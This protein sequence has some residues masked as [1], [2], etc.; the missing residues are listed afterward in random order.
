MKRPSLPLSGVKVVDFGQYIAGPAVAMVLAD[1]G[2]IVVHIDPPSGPLWDS[3]ANATLNRNKLIVEIDLKTEEGLSQAQALVAEADIVVENFRPG[4]LSRL[5]IDFTA[6]RKVRPELITVSIP[7]FASND[8]LRREWRAFEAVIAASSGVFTDMGLDRVLMGVIP[9]FSPLPLASAYGTMLAASAAVLALQA[10]ERSGIGDHIE[11]PL[12]CAVMEALAYN[13]CLVENFPPRYTGHRSREIAQRREANLPLNL[14]YQ[15]VQDL[16]DPF[17][18]NSGYMCKD[19]RMFSIACAGHK[20]HIK[21]CLQALGLYD[22]LVSEGLVEQMDHYLALPLPKYWH[23]EITTRM[24]AVFLTRTSEE[25]ERIFRESRIAGSPQRSLKEWMSN[26]HA[27]AAGVVVEVDDPVFGRMTQPGP[28]AWLEETGEMMLN[29]APRKWVAFDEAIAA[30]SAIPVRR[31]P[32]RPAR[33]SSGWLDGVRVLD[34]S[35][36]IAGPHTAY[37]LARFGAEVIKIDPALPLYNC[38]WTV[39]MGMVNMCGKHS[40][41]VDIASPGG[42]KV[43][44]RLVKS[45]D[46]IVW[47]ATDQEVKRKGLHLEGLK[48]LNPDVIFCQVDCF[49]GV[50]GGPRSDDPGYDDIAQAA[51]GIML[52]FGGSPESPEEHAHY[53]TIDALGAYSAALGIAAAL[54]QKGRTGHVGRPRTSLSALSGLLQVPFCYDYAGRDPFDEPAGPDAKGYNALARLYRTASGR[55]LMLNAVESDLPR[56]AQVEGL[57]GLGD[58]PAE[59]RATFLSTAMEKA[60]AE[61]WLSR[62]TAADIGAAICENIDAIRSANSRPADGTPGTDRGSYSFSIYRDHP[63][64]HTVT[65][66]DPYAI[67]SEAGKVYA[68]SPAEKYGAST[69]RLLRSFQYTEADID[70]LIAAGN[71]SE[72]WSHEYLPT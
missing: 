64:G 51:T 62:L 56:L 42:R 11:A 4:V 45:V 25:W 22:E 18:R 16:H 1:L 20:V 15:S 5:G 72:S 50:R 29:P 57:E 46:V 21:R 60:S 12:V 10:R 55:T 9:Y 53:G 38:S 52:R 14:S 41:L 26:E 23:D 36:V 43:F 66:L 59:D 67:R 3:P 71:I 69:R 32:A 63:S 48:A 37:Y 44:E 70:A 19:G 35:N 13:A 31:P 47:N 40:A 17:Y 24:K 33:A 7:G 30:L 39:S 27:T 8:Q 58:V 49:S 28:M 6:L 61:D 34:L 54:Y 2:A 68:L 65:Q